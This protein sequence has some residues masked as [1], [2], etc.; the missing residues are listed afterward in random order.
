MC[1]SNITFSYNGVEAGFFNEG[2]LSDCLHQV[3]LQENKT[4]EHLHYVLCTDDF[5]LDLNRRF[6]QHDTL[7]D[8]LTFPE[9]YRPVVAEI[10][11][12]LT[13]VK[14]NA[15]LHSQGHFIEEF[16]RVVLHGLLHM[17]EYGD[18][19][20]EEKSLMRARENHYLRML[21]RH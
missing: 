11:I 2:D 18:A 20:P 5:L 17:F 15:I 6:L 10:Y 9:C 16:Q 13:R 1:E 7:T 12:S 21:Q 3:A 8:I 19:T 4:I 14:E